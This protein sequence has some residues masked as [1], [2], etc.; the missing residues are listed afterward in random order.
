MNADERIGVFVSIIDRMPSRLT[1][2]VALLQDRRLTLTGTLA[3]GFGD[4][5]FDDLLETATDAGLATGTDLAAPVER[6]AYARFGL[7]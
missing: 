5:V 2:G 4:D 7:A 1:E 3:P 6:A